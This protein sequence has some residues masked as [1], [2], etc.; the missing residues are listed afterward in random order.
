MT[1][2]EFAQLFAI[3]RASPGPTCLI[4]T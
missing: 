1:D 2:S 4:V 3:A